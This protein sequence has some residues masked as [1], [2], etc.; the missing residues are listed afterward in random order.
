MSLV[1]R[2]RRLVA[3]EVYQG[4]AV[5]KGKTSIKGGVVAAVAS[6]FK[7]GVIK[8]GM[9]VLDYGAGK[10]AR[11]ADWLRK[12]GVKV[13][14]YDPF[15]ST[16]GDG[17]EMGSVVS[18]KPTGKFDVAFSCYVLNV[19]PAGVETDV[20]ANVAKAAPE[21]FHVVRS[22]SDLL[23][24]VGRSLRK[25]SNAV[26]KQWFANEFAT[27]QDVKDLED[28]TLSKERIRDFVIFGVKTGKDR[29]QRIPTIALNSAP[30]SKGSAWEMYKG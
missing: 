12:Q 29:F 1:S 23:N 16:G 15:N 2:Y 6:L 19:V 10:V 22:K 11:N 8:P 5:E 4:P 21:R 17:W 13:Y 28:G 18:K 9:K 25:G 30:V 20:V 3:Q 14:A 27:P 26:L 7:S 24:Q